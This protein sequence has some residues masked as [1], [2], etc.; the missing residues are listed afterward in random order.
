MNIPERIS[1]YRILDKLGEGGMGVVY[2]AEDERLG[3]RVALKLIRPDPAEANAG[4][5][6]IREA[7]VAA[8]V[9]HPS[10]CQVFDLGEWERQPFLVMELVE[11][12]SLAA[13]LARGPIPTLETLRIALSI[14]EALSAIHAHGITHRDLKPSNVFV[15]ATGVKVLDF[16]LARPLHSP[17][18]TTISLVTQM[19]TVVGTPQYAAPEQLSGADF[20]ARADLFSMGVILFEMLTG[21]PPFTGPTLGALVHAVIYDTPPVLTGSAAVAAVDQVVHRALAKTPEDRYQT[22]DALAAD[23]REVTGLVDIDRVAEV[24]PLTRLAVLPFR[25]LKPD[26]EIDYL[27]LSLA[28]AIVTSLSGLESLVVRSTL[29]SARY[30]GVSDLNLIASD[31]A[32]D[33]VLT[34]SLLR[35]NDRLRVSAELVSVPAGDTF[36]AQTTQVASDAIFDLHDEL[37]QRVVTSL[38]LVARDRERK[39]NIGS[40]SAKAFDL[41]LRGMQLRMETSSWRQARALFDRCVALDPTFAPA[42]AELGRLDRVLG[43]YEDQALRVRAE[44]ALQRALELDSDNGAAH[45]YY[46]Q[47]E[48]DLGR[49]EAALT[50]LLE[51]VRQRRA[52]PQVYAA[53]VQACRYAGLLAESVAA[54]RQAG[55]LD[56]TVSTSV[57]HTYYMQGDY[58]RALEEG[59]RSSDPL[60]A[61]VLGAMGRDA[62]AIKA[63]QREE[64][65][66]TAL[67]LL[68]SFSTGLRAALEGK[69][70]EALAALAPFDTVVINDG[71]ALFYVAEIYATLGIANRALAMLVRA[72]DGGFVCTPAF[73]NDPYLSAVR[74]SPEW[75]RLL[76]RVR[77]K[78][79]ALVDSFVRAAGRTLLGT[80]RPR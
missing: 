45:H 50:R 48:I 18:D 21:K 24:R 34:G 4:A 3:R 20:D 2:V 38:P 28:D 62:D 76:E 71:E 68:R 22:A 77:A 67:P 52:E 56:P 11:G 55:R 65:R 9:S 39:A 61:R 33:M 47:L 53:L 8:S 74:S 73:E 44:A 13:R 75:P 27:G 49:V 70:E 60:E 17:S 57:L 15:T 19:G 35:S 66:Y 42:W 12:E 51:R 30:A 7:R 37:A 29:K 72:V 32:V 25:L 59:H 36:W 79:A 63:A 10:I 14:V 5:R 23:L 58:D 26:P 54:H 69:T 41:Y 43:K 31:L 6:L 80:S 78:Q 46:A 40:A 16:G 1:H 64:E